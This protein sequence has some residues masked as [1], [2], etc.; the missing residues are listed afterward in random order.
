VRQ[1]RLGTFGALLAEALYARVR[2]H[3]MRPAQV[4]DMGLVGFEDHAR[5]VVYLVSQEAFKEACEWL[6]EGFKGL[7]GSPEG[8]LQLFGQG[9]GDG[10]WAPLEMVADTWPPTTAEMADGFSEVEGS[11]TTVGGVRFH[12]SDYELFAADN[13]EFVSSQSGDSLWGAPL[14][15]SVGQASGV[16]DLVGDDGRVRVKIRQ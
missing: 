13:D 16:I 3:T 14:E 1:E 11:N 9:A 5:G 6:P 12:P 15:A 8:C 4:Y 7:M 2:G 10:P